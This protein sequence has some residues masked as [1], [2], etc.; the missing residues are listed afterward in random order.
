MLPTVLHV[1]KGIRQQLRGMRMYKYNLPTAFKMVLAAKIGYFSFFPTA[2][3]LE[4][5]ANYLKT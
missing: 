3:Q 1:I 2:Y 5:K 4:K